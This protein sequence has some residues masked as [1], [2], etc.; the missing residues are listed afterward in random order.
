M[1]RRLARGD[2]PKPGGGGATRRRGRGGGGKIWEKEEAEEEEEARTTVEKVSCAIPITGGERLHP[3]P[4]RR[5]N[6]D[7]ICGTPLHWR[8]TCNP[9]RLYVCARC[10]G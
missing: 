10:T 9:R 7:S 1:E 5:L 4:P 6:C 2:A 8:E 3:L